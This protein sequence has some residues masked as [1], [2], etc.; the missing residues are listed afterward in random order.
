MDGENVN[1]NGVSETDARGDKAAGAAVFP[2]NGRGET[3][4]EVTSASRGCSFCGWRFVW[5]GRLIKCYKDSA[6]TV[7]ARMASDRD[8]WYYNMNHKNRG[9]AIIFNHENFTNPKLKTRCG[10][11]TDC[12]NLASTLRSLR[13]EVYTYFDASYSKVMSVISE[14][15]N[16]DHSDNDCFLMAVLSHGEQNII[17]AYDSPYQPEDLW[18]PFTAD[19]CP[20]LAGKPKLFFIQACQGDRLDPGVTLMKRTETDSGPMSYRIPVHADFLIAYSTIPGFYSWRNTQRGSW[21]MQ[22]LCEELKKHCYSLDLLTILTFVNRRVATD[23]QS[24]VPG[25]NEMDAQKQIPCI[26]YMLTRLLKFEPK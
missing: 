16:M 1:S 25:N 10:T 26:T 13:F 4:T 19:K 24:N 21:F 11:K 8:A 20:S 9:I 22:A 7:T 18:H 5:E 14:V 15:R 2:Q 17:H 23:Y 3:K 6:E 12:E